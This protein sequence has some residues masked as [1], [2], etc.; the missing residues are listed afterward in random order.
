MTATES[1]SKSKT[2]LG[3]CKIEGDTMT[4]A[5]G[6]SRPKTFDADDDAGVLFMKRTK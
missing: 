5:L 3:I 6:K 1:E 2:I 4:I